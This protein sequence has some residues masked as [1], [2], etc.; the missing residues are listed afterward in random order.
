MN[1]SR[2]WRDDGDLDILDEARSEWQN[3]VDPDESQS[4]ADEPG[5]LAPRTPRGPGGPKWSAEAT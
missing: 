2:H 5:K 4:T 3:I 1:G